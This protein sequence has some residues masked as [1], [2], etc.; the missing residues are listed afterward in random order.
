MR[1]PITKL[2]LLLTTVFLI[3]FV[4]AC[5]PEEETKE[6]EAYV[7]SISVDTNTVPEN[8]VAGQVDLS[9]IDLIIIM[10]DGEI[11]TKSIE[12]KMIFTSDRGKLLR[13]GTHHISIIY[14]G[15]ST[16]FSITIGEAP[17]VEYN[18]TIYDGAILGRE[19]IDG[20]WEGI[21]SAGERVTIVAT[22]KSEAGYYFDSWKVGGQVY[23]QNA[24]CD[25]TINSNISIYAHY[26]LI[27]YK[28]SFNSSG[29]T[30]VA[31]MQT[32]TVEQAPETTRA[33][34]VF[35]GWREPDTNTIITYPFTVPKNITLTAVWEPLGLIYDKAP[36]ASGWT[37][38]GYEYN[39]PRTSL[40]IPDSHTDPDNPK[41]TFPVVKIARDAF[42]NAT[43]LRTLRLNKYISEIEDYAFAE[44]INMQSFEEDP[45]S[46]DIYEVINGVLYK[47][48]TLVAFPAGRM[49][50]SFDV[51]RVSIIGKAAFANANI[52]SIN[53]KT[54]LLNI[55]ADAFNSR[56]ID[57]V[58][59]HNAIN[60]EM[61]YQDN[62]FSSDINKIFIVQNSYI[63]GYITHASFLPFADKIE[64]LVQN[65]L[66]GI[67]DNF[68]YRVITRDIDGISTPTIEIIGADRS[69]KSITIPITRI[70]GKDV[71]SI[72]RNAFSYCYNLE[73]VTV[74]QQSKLDRIL[75]G[76]F[77]NTKW[78]EQP[79]H[80]YIKDGLIIMNGILFRCLEDR[81]EY[82]I[83]FNV[84]RLGEEC[85]SNK[86][87]LEKVIFGVDDNDQRYIVSIENGAFKNCIN[88]KEIIIPKKVE[89]LGE[90]AFENTRLSAFGFEEDSEL[91]TIEDFCFLNASHL[92]AVSFGTAIE[93][94]G[95]GVFNGCYSLESIAINGSIDGVNE[96]FVVK[97]GVLFQKNKDLVGI[98]DDFGRILHTYPAGRTAAVYQLPYDGV[99]GVTHI[100]EFAFYY[101][102]IAAVVLPPTMES[103]VSYSFVIP[104]LV[105]IEFTAGLE[106][107]VASYNILFPVFGAEHIILKESDTASYGTWGAPEGIIKKKGTG[108]G[109]V[110]TTNLVGLFDYNY[111]LEGVDRNDTFIYRFDARGL[112]IIGAE[113]TSA[114][115]AVPS[116]IEI[117]ATPRSVTGIGS[118]AFN[119]S[120]LT[121][122]LLPSTVDTIKAYAFY[123]SSALKRLTINRETAPLL[124]YSGEEEEAETVLSFNPATIIQNALLF[125]PEGFKDNYVPWTTSIDFVID[126]G[127]QPQIVFN[128]NK[129]S[130]AVLLDGEG[131]PIDISTLSVI[132][133][134][135]QT[136]RE[137][138]TFNGW[139]DN[140]DFLGEPI[141]FPY[142]KHRNIIFYARWGVRAFGIVYDTAGG[143]FE[144]TPVTSVNY[145]SAYNLTVP[146]KPGYVFVGWFDNSQRQYSDGNGTGTGIGS[147]EHIL[148]ATWGLTADA[149]LVAKWSPREFIITYDATG[150]TVAES[151][152]TVSYNATYALE[153][154]VREG[155]TF[156]G[157]K[158]AQNSWL[159][160][161]DG[162]STNAWSYT[163][164]ITAYAVWTALS[165]QVRFNDGQGTSIPVQTVTFGEQFIFPVP[166][167]TGSV[168]FG[169][170]DGFGGTGK[171]Y[172]DQQGNSIRAWDKAGV[173]IYMYAQWPINISDAADFD[174]VRGSP[175]GSYILTNN[176]TLDEE[177]VPI[178]I[179]QNSPFTGI[180]DGNG[181]SILN[182]TITN[183]NFGYVGLVGYNNGTIRNLNLGIIYIDEAASNTGKAVINVES[184][185]NSY[186]NFYA[187]GLVGYN[188]TDGVITNCEVAADITVHIFCENRSMY[189]GGMVG[190]NEG[191]VTDCY[192][193]TSLTTSFEEGLITPGT[194]WRGAFAGFHEL[195][196][197]IDS[198]RYQRI[199]PSPDFVSVACGN[200][201]DQLTFGEYSAT[202]GET[203]QDVWDE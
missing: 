138:Y 46:D 75:E 38:V 72:G 10:S 98:T 56:T 121:E 181:Y 105:Y 110:D 47:D 151:T 53:I 183:E 187:G 109:R 162:A 114:L 54:N 37:V 158:D 48:D 40:V 60:S 22:D 15:M 161:I 165:Y 134:E 115:L 178:G 99:T 123:Y 104:Q 177:W 95:R 108:E 31:Q 93:K 81:K 88:L 96:F 180:L 17:V 156:Q 190:Y 102:N 189:V 194:E 133:S 3:F 174:I 119:G 86:T 131:N 143:T 12:D 160:Y 198:C 173:E 172:T 139:Y 70:E 36:T 144:E 82:T 63:G 129:G 155:Y 203:T 74:A 128:T 58:I 67:Y 59:F 200:Q 116:T 55:G 79:N 137:G 157:W 69:L 113:R 142:E 125:V 168:F 106:L 91:K 44:C 176:I 94:I 43:N 175:E 92:K 51:D 136:T 68:L 185:L 199:V 28:V 127:S 66:I 39:G 26:E 152:A 76:A 30:G 140:E 169:W 196:G 154:P 100:N 146:V 2:I 33:E 83:P 1:K 97:D 45:L 32:R 18:L 24:S 201:N 35:I 149:Q 132:P 23:N 9:Q 41:D 34:Y 159:T 64:E 11:V 163:Q 148:N 57:N 182:L 141:I 126:I 8:S 193:K 191:E 145:G 184:G 171:Q 73:T 118:Y 61:A 164:D 14:G 21:F 42:S 124:E 29:G 65:P 101:S 170:Y 150:G 50:V 179:D 186:Q 147:S 85:F 202:F 20:V 153:V 19:P 78:Q 6:E 135:P 77:D 52:G 111:T 5:A 49:L 27:K 80:N 188:G 7:V 87:L 192:L 122:V 117:E 62:L 4:T 16:R 107:A 103:I 112:Y 90:R 167:K 130:D 195:S 120:M 84:T 71:T 197:R 25:I 13:T 89:K 166:T